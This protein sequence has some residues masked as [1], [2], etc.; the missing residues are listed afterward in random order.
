SEQVADTTELAVIGDPFLDEISRR[1]GSTFAAQ[2]V[3][4]QAGAA[5]SELIHTVSQRAGIFFFF[6]SDCAQCELQAPLLK[7][8][9][10]EGYTIIPIS[11][12]GNPLP[13]SPFDFFKVDSGHAKAL[14]VQTYPALF[15]ASPDGEFAALGQSA[16]SLPELK[17]RILVAA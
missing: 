10:Y 8:L 14:G 17:H 5:R 15:L 4:R 13:N 3:D 2:N 12:D 6:E 16:M 11:V 1:P 7:T 9:E